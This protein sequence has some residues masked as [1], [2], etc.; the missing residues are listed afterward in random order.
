[1]FV[2]KRVDVTRLWRTV[3]NERI[4]NLKSSLNAITVTKLRIIGWEVNTACMLLL[5]HIGISIRTQGGGEVAGA[6]ALVPSI[7]THG[8]PI[9][10]WEDNIKKNVEDFFRMNCIRLP[11]YTTI[12]GLL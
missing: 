8:R 12:G 1:M 4:S 2:P 5:R 11:V 7:H 3:N 10:M 6:I 9:R